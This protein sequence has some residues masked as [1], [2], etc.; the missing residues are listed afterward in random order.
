MNMN[1]DQQLLEQERAELNA[2][3]NKGITFDVTDTTFDV[4]RTWY[5]RKRYTRREIKRTFTISEPTLGTLDRLSAEWVE[6]AID[7]QA[8]KSDDA[9]ERARTLV[10]N[11]A[12]RC[13][14]IIAIAALGGQRLIARPVGHNATEY[15]EDAG[16]IRELTSLFMRTIKPSVMYKLVV[17]I[18]AMCNFGDFTNSIRLMLADRTTMPIRIEDEPKV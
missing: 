15:I 1:K 5:G 2:L 3:I 4:H 17:M 6:F 16:K 9:M 8:M 14:R 18:N 13:A 11:N 12:E 7:E 10:A